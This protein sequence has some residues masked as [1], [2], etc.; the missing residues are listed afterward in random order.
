MS[1][2][3]HRRRREAPIDPMLQ[4]ERTAMAWQRTALG[5]GGI[6]ALLLHSGVAVAA[7]LGGLGLV[8]AVVLLVVTERRYERIVAHV[9]AGRRASSPALVRT[10]SVATVALAAGALVLVVLPVR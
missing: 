3:L 10:V 4:S 5:V 6:G 8:A 9:S 2:W 1:P 7:V